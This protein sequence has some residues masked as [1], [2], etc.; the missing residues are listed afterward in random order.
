MARLGCCA[1]RVRCDSFRTTCVNCEIIAIDIAQFVQPLS[2]HVLT[3]ILRE[4]PDPPFTRS[5]LL[6]TRPERPDGN[7]AAEQPDQLAPPY[8]S[9]TLVSRPAGLGIEAGAPPTKG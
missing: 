7:R 9:I 1:S 3:A 8:H 5:R 2:N 4:Q 6:R